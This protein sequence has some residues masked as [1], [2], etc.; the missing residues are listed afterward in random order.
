MTRRQPT[1]L[2]IDDDAV[3]RQELSSHLATAG[4]GVL[5]AASGKKG[6][7]LFAG[8]RLTWWFAT[9]TCRERVA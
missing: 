3:L 1:I 6:L 9:C 2:V 5:E 8:K 7:A 4:Y